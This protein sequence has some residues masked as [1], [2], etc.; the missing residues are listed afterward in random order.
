[1]K[2]GKFD[3]YLADLATL[4]GPMESFFESVMVNVPEMPI[5]ANRLLLLSAV[6][7]LY[8]SFAD[9]SAF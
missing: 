3:L 7:E 1:M 2:H 9:F 4:E 5:R 6:L 8:E